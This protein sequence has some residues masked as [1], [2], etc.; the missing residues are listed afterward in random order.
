MPSLFPEL[1]D[2]AVL[3]T[4]FIR[5]TTGLFFFVLGE[6]LLRVLHAGDGT[7]GLSKVFGYTYGTAQVLIGALLV[8]GLFTQGAAIAGLVASLVFIVSD[9][10]RGSHPSERYVHILLIANCVALL[11]LGA[12]AFARDLPL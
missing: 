2:F 7:Q 10:K 12:G 3:G 4:F 1:F 8:V 5:I 9:R 11:F 6:K